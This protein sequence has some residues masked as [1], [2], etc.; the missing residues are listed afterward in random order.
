MTLVG[1]S[2]EVGSVPSLH[3]RILTDIT[4]KILSGTWPPGHRIPFEHE[5]TEAYG[6]S[7]MTVNK[8][9]TQL[10]KAG[11][12]ERRRRAGTVVTR[13]R[14]Q[15]AIL[16]IHDI[17]AEVEAL[18]LTYGFSLI[19]RARRPASLSDR[20]ALGVTAKVPVLA[21]ECLHSASG[22]PFCHEAR[23]INLAIVPDA[24][25]A[26]LAE[27]A[28]GPW[29]V[30]RIP[31]SAAEHRIRAAAADTHRAALLGVPDGA[32]CLVVERRTWSASEPVTHV[33]FTYPGESHTLVARFTPQG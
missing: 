21:L 3:Q 14:S 33:R 27:T 25:D 17:R 7:R 24:E 1:A 18:S 15:A 6:C 4:D 22:V 13:P 20:D 28:P 26:P 23:L 12:V 32:P 29:L 2:P 5:L 19:R 11:L 9:I 10:A 8:A 31:W 30:S 16:E